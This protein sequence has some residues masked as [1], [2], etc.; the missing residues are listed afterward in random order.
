MIQKTTMQKARAWRGPA[1]FSYGFRPFF[2]FG[3]IYAG[4]AVALWTLWRY[5]LA[6]LPS[7]FPPVAWH[8]HELLFG[9]GPAVVAGFLLTA[10]P[11]W[12]GRLPVVGWPLVVLFALWCVGRLAMLLAPA[13]APVALLA[14]TLVFP[15]TLAAVIGREIVAGDNWR[16]LK[17]LVA[18]AVIALA[19]VIFQVEVALGGQSVFGERL[20]VGALVMLIAIIGGRIIPSFTVNWLKRVNP[21]R[22]PKPFDRYDT[23]AMI[24]AGLALVAWVLLPAL[25]GASRPVAAL[26]LAAGL[27]H[28]VRLTRWAPDRTWREPLVAVLHVSYLFVPIGF[29]LAAAAAWNGEAALFTATVH[30]WTVGAIGMMTLSVMTRATRGHTGRALAAPADTTV[31]YLAIFAAALARIGA[32]LA[33]QH[34]GWLLPVAGLCWSLAFFGF[35]LVYGPMLTMRR[36]AP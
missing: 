15:V 21:G 25:G 19:Q 27:A 5:D 29:F 11:N 3:A 17:V 2:F 35:A 10:V 16:N 26:L 14:L 34:A 24:L 36:K 31:I 28:L 6:P 22:L 13:G 1:L 20:A 33:P 32:A 9:Y 18:V 23:F 7:A 8:A 4:F 30:A 12:T